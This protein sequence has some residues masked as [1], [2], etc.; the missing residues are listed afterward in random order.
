MGRSVILPVTRGC[1]LLY[2]EE[3]NPWSFS[4]RRRTGGSKKM[5]RFLISKTQ[6]DS[7]NGLIKQPLVTGDIKVKFFASAP[8]RTQD[9]YNVGAWVW[10]SRAD[11][12]ESLNS[13]C[14]TGYA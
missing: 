10:F 4:I 3:M 2:P 8:L 6:I 5:Y 14:S 1:N 9:G 12:A 11:T 13:P 7:T